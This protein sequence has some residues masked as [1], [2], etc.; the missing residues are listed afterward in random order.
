MVSAYW[1]DWIDGTYCSIDNP[2]IAEIYSENP[3]Y[4]EGFCED[5]CR[6]NLESMPPGWEGEGKQFCCDYEA[7]ED[8]TFN[9]YI[10]E[11]IEIEN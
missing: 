10:Y 4:N 11:G 6:T 2:L 8:K 5:F 7:W 9:C 3:E 1:G